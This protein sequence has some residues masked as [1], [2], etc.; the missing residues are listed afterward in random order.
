[1]QPRAPNRRR[2]HRRR[3]WS[4]AVFSMA[5][6]RH[7]SSFLGPIAT[8]FGLLSNRR[9]KRPSPFRARRCASAASAR[10]VGCVTRGGSSMV[11]DLNALEARV[12]GAYE[13]GRALRALGRSTPLLAIGAL[14]LLLDRLPVP[15]LRINGLI[16]R[17][18]VLLHWRGQQAGKGM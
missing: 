3:R 2:S 6:S 8:Y 18:A 4:S 12:R 1:M 7:S 13:K 16:I 15:V 9:S 5:R 14:I 10:S 11:V 17:T